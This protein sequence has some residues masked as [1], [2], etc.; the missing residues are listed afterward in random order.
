MSADIT[1]L[2]GTVDDITISRREALRYLGYRGQQQTADM[3]A[4]FDRAHDCLRES[5]SLKACYTTLDLA[6]NDETLDFGAFSLQSR[7]LAKNLSGCRS[8]YLFAATL[9]VGVDKGS[10]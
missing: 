3:D 2:S 5:A 8:V 10:I 4:L 6:A 1:L 7:S 9:G